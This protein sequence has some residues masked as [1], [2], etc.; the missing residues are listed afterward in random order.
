MNES[1]GNCTINIWI[2]TITE[3]RQRAPVPVNVPQ[4]TG[5]LIGDAIWIVLHIQIFV[6]VKDVINIPINVFGNTLKEKNTRRLCRYPIFYLFFIFCIM[7]VYSDFWSLL[8][9]KEDAQYCDKPIRDVFIESL[10]IKNFL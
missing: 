5:H 7:P 3:L 2:G 8:V 4:L 6:S 9:Y 1:T 10:F